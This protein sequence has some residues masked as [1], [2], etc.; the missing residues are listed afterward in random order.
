V[1]VLLLLLR[2]Y[3]NPLAVANKATISIGRECE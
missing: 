3:S 2:K 1:G